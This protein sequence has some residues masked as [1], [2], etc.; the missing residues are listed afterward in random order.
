MAVQSK[1]ALAKC[2]S[3]VGHMKR[4]IFKGAFSKAPEQRRR[5]VER[6]LT[7]QKRLDGKDPL[8]SVLE[9]LEG[10]ELGSASGLGPSAYGQGRRSSLLSDDTFGDLTEYSGA[11]HVPD[12]VTYKELFDRIERIERDYHEMAGHGG[13][14]Q[15]PAG[16][17]RA[18]SLDKTGSSRASGARGSLHRE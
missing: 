3:K 18:P 6:N 13:Y 1:E 14:P 10:N 12:E 8:A 4:I 16:G 9:S 5:V 11:G 17:L 2:L 15:A 7:L